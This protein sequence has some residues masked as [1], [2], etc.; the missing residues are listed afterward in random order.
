MAQALIVFAAM[1]ALDLVWARYTAAVTERR[2]TLASSYSAVII[3]LG[4][5]A[6]INYID[7]PRMIVPAMLGAA[8]GTFIGIR[9]NINHGVQK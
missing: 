6:T 2:R 7:D 4:A 5:F 1:F 8:C 3:A 9:R